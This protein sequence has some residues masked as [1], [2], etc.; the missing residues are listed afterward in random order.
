MLPLLAKSAADAFHVLV[1][2]SEDCLNKTFHA[3]VRPL[4][5]QRFFST[6]MPILLSE[7][8]NTQSH[9]VRSMFYRAIGHVISNTPLAAVLTE[10]KKL[11]PVLLDVISVL[12]EDIHNK[13]MIYNLLLVFSGLLMDKRGQDIAV[14]NAHVIINCMTGLLSYPHKMLVRE[15]AI[16]CLVAVSGM[17]HTRIYP[18]R[19]QVLRALSKVLDDPKRTVRQEAVRCHQ[20]WSSIA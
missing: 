8:K 15:T 7:V 16:Q 5:K 10:T 4:Y 18:M 13:D 20:A 11:L 6:V 14:E 12:S 2:D 9:T 19:I 3:T 17:P 1:S